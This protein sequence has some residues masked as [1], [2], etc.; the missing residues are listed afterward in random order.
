MARPKGFEPLTPRFVVWCSIQ[1]S[2]GRV[3]HL[4]DRLRRPVP[5]WL[6]HEMQA[7]LGK[8]AT[9]CGTANYLRNKRLEVATD[10]EIFV[11]SI[12]AQHVAVHIAHGFQ[13]DIDDVAGCLDCRILAA[14]RPAEWFRNDA[15]DD[16]QLV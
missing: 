12:L 11:T 15:V 2:Y 1:L 13:R 5:N 3:P 14:M 16:L 4:R 8:K 9:I 10:S 7:D 6:A